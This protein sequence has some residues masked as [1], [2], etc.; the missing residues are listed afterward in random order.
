MPLLASKHDFANPLAKIPA[1]GVL[2]SASADPARW[3]TFPVSSVAPGSIPGRD[4]P[5]RRKVEFTALIPAISAARAD[6]SAESKQPEKAAPV[7]PL[8]LFYCSLLWHK[9]HDSTAGWDLIH[10][11]R[12][13]DR[14]ARVVAAGLL[15]KTEDARLSIRDVRRAGN[16]KSTGR[17]PTKLFDD[18]NSSE[19]ENMKAPYGLE[20]IENC[21]SCKLR[22]DSWF[23]GLSPEVLKSFSAATR[24]TTY[25]G[26]ALLFVEGQTPRAAFVLCSGKVKLS[27]TSREG[28]VL[29]VKV[30]EAGE[31]LGLSAVVSGT[32]YQVTAET[33]VPCQVNFVEREALLRLIEKNG[34]LGLHSAQALSNEFQSAYRDIHDLV[35]ARSS[36]G[37]LARLLLSWTP[38]HSS[39]GYAF[40]ESANEVRIRSSLTHEEMA[41]M[42]GASRET[43]TRLLSDLKKK[44]LIRLEGPV[45]V[46]RNRMALEALAS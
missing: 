12:S 33:T 16:L 36:A 1:Q 41:Q 27:T 40:G 3:D 9:R 28:K 31:V 4:I 32:P 2:A 30:A 44:E 46:I 38:G 14:S 6:A 13:W 10:C 25:P 5:L 20:V 22:K 7:D 35:L 24:P 34:E 26:G 8:F 21:L 39:L 45:L 19:A 43:V 15:A 18:D 23:C 17:A 42:I 37:K 11:L 29:I